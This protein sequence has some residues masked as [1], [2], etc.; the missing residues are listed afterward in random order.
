[1][2]IGK[3]R[4]EAGDKLPVLLSSLQLSSPRIVPHEIGGEQVVDPAQLTLVPHFF[5][6]LLS[7][8]LVAFWR[9]SAIALS[10]HY[11]RC[12]I[13]RSTM[14]STAESKHSARPSARSCGRLKGK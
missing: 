12:S 4:A 3:G 10:I 11:A 8:Q 5:P 2:H 13:I 14:I 7:E 9:H 6:H 1:V